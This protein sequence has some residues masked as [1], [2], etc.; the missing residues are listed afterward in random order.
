M[1]AGEVIAAG[2]DCEILD[3][4]PG[5]VLRRPFDGRSLAEEGE[6][7]RYAHDAGIPVP[8]YFGESDGG[9]VLER[10]DGPTMLDAMVRK[11]LLR[12]WGREL[13]SLH[14]QVHALEAPPTVT[15]RAT[16]DGDRLLHGDLHPLNVLIS[17]KGP[18]IIDWSNAMVGDAAFDIA[19]AWILMATSDIPEPQPI[20]AIV[21]GFRRLFV[22][23]FLTAAGRDAALAYA[24]IAGDYRRADPNVTDGERERVAALVRRTGRTLE[25]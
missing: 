16:P 1:T 23:H 19:L 3:Y 24:S 7:M 8:Q 4:G 15:R 13:A 2:R 18:V 20:R 17:P 10:I 14:R 9:I 6:V 5:K 25:A 11:P 12:V 21:G 22:R